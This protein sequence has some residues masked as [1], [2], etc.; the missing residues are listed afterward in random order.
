MKMSQLF[1]QTLRDA[2]GDAEIESH[3]LL[4]RS[5]F[6]RQLAAGIFTMMPLALRTE[7]K[8]NAILRREINAIGGQEIT[9]P[10]VHPSDIWEETGRLFQIDAEMSRFKDRS[11]RDMVFRTPRIGKD[12]DETA[13][14]QN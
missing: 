5:G 8:I 4:A 10:V 6:I 2:P 7:E 12:T 1:S 9:M 11:D 13:T 14:L 3:K